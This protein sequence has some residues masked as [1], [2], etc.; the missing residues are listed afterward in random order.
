MGTLASSSVAGTGF[1][2]GLFSLELVAG[3]LSG[4]VCSRFGGNFL[5]RFRALWLFPHIRR[6]G[7][8]VAREKG[9]VNERLAPAPL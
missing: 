8:D 9:A 3:L 7:G 5:G 1:F 4:L 2:P 6:E